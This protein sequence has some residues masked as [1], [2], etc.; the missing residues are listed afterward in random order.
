MSTSFIGE[1]FHT[2]VRKEASRFMWLGAALV[3]IGLA[4]LIFPVVSSLVA[5]LFVGWMLILSGLATIFGSFS[6]R[7]AG[8]FFGALLFGLL[9]LGAGVFIIARPLGGALAITLSLGVIFM[10]Q[11]AFEAF[12]AFE[13]RPARSWTWMLVSAL[14]SIVLAVVILAGWPGTSLITLGVIIGV[15]FISS[16][17]AYLFLGGAARRE[18]GA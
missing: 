15:N 10:V 6:M 12:L 8:P 1:A 14:A 13:L 2:Q 17:V 16:G 7:G 18:A 5:T 11:G 3:I 9:S 4:A